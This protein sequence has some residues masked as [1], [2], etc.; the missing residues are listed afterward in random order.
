MDGCIEDVNET[1]WEAR[2]LS[3]WPPEV[4]SSASSC[5]RLPQST[6]FGQPPLG[7]LYKPLWPG[8]AFDIGRPADA[9]NEHGVPGQ[10]RGATR[11]DGDQTG[12]DAVAQRA[13]YGNTGLMQVLYRSGPVLRR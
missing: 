3:L 8:V 2:W 1:T 6:S 9:P 12:K 7:Q 10:H 5:L 13:W 4:I 11:S